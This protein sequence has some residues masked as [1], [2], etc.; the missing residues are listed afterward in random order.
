MIYDKLENLNLYIDC[1]PKDAFDF[2]K[3]ISSDL[4]CGRYNISDNIYAN[5]EIYNT[6][7]ISNAQFESH[8]KYIDIQILLNG[9]EDIFYA[10][11]SDLTVNV[12]YNSEKDITFYKE[13]VLPF[14]KVTLDGTNF[15]MLYPHE[16][17]APQ[18]CAG[19]IPVLVKK[20][21]VKIK[22]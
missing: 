11:K 16:A 19:E 14:S 21:V 12:P 2:I 5:V 9:V 13:N 3:A 20:V 22:I 10:Y 15:V 6:K 4:S 1:I 7:N 18:V 17:H 8:E